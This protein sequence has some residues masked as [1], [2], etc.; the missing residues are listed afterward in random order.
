METKSESEYVESRILDRCN[1]N[2]DVNTY[3]AYKPSR[4]SSFVC[5]GLW[6]NVGMVPRI[7]K[8]RSILPWFDPVPGCGEQNILWSDSVKGYDDKAASKLRRP[9]SRGPLN[10]LK[11]VEQTFKIRVKNA[12]FTQEIVKFLSVSQREK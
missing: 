3:V 2:K 10:V 5:F 12:M 9:F 4:V 8:H 1:T 11:H 7:P 6:E